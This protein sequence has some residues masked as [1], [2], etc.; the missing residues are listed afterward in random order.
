MR[1]SAKDKLNQIMV[2]RNLFLIYYVMCMIYY[3]VFRSYIIYSILF[4]CIHLFCYVLTS[5][6]NKNTGFININLQIQ[7]KNNVE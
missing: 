1:L 4:Y 7:E 6:F 3:I 2:S 5:L